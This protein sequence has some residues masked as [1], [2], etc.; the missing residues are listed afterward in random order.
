LVN[1][2]NP[3]PNLDQVASNYLIGDIAKKKKP[4]FFLL[5]FAIVHKKLFEQIT[6]KFG[7]LKN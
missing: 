7:I 5:S 6:K 4:V 3:E 2:L 1:P